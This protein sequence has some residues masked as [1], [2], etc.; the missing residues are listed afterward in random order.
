MYSLSFLFVCL[1]R[2]V[3]WGGIIEIVCSALMLV[4]NTW[5]EISQVLFVYFC[6]SVSEVMLMSSVNV[7]LVDIDD[8]RR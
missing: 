2:R 4:N 1:W 7:V 6:F 5:K 8:L 3:G